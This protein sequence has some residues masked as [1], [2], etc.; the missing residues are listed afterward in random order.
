MESVTSRIIESFMIIHNFDTLTH[1]SYV[2]R[3][4]V[5]EFP[6][7][8]INLI[9]SRYGLGTTHVAFKLHTESNLYLIAIYTYVAACGCRNTSTLSAFKLHRALGS[10]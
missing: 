2:S 1:H 6:T 4:M 3:S 5:R 10:S 7:S 9:R 8:H